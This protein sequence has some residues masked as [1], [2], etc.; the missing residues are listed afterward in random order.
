MNMYRLIGFFAAFLV[1][2]G[3]YGAAEA[4][5]FS[6]PDKIVSERLSGGV[7]AYQ[8]EYSDLYGGPQVV[9]LVAADLSDPAVEI[10]VG[11]CDNKTRMT[12][13]KMAERDN[14]LAAVNFGYFNM[15]DPSSPAGALKHGG[16]VEST[17]DV[18]NGS[19]GLIGFSGSAVSF[20]KP[21][22]EAVNGCDN[23]RAGFP[24]LVWNGGIYDGIGSYDHVP[25]RHN[26]T[27]IGVT[28][29]NVLY[30]VT[31]D[32][33]AAGHA[34]GVSCYD[35]ADYMQRLG[36]VF[37]INMDG[38]GSTTMWTVRHGV[39]NYPSDNRAFDHAGER[40]VYDIFYVRDKASSS[41]AQPSGAGENGSSETLADAA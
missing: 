18:G 20:F 9:S 17:S 19:G 7:A 41:V 10:G 28:A 22:D 11:V 12:V 23:F 4:D 30:L 13:S 5:V 39:F 6:S 14:A 15:V 2:S 27:A 32:G 33:R 38:G 40:R 37:A 25:G 35:L 36:C 26:R 31:F 24:L 3:V 29:G 1:F 8:Y 16:E 21:G 34:T